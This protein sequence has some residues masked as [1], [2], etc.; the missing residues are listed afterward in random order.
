MKL[1]ITNSLYVAGAILLGSAIISQFQ[2]AELI[3]STVLVI[4]SIMLLVWG[5]QKDK[6]KVKCAIRSKNPRVVTLVT[7]AIV[8]VFG[9][10]LFTMGRL[11][12]LWSQV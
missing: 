3:S 11:I 2:Q 10:L 4:I 12:Y 6:A 9:A 5:Y 1:T 7:I 8:T